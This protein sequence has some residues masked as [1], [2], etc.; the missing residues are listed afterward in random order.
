MW[1]PV[2]ET[3]PIPVAAGQGIMSRAG[4]QPGRTRAVGSVPMLRL[5]LALLLLAAAPAAAQVEGPDLSGEPSGPAQ[6]ATQVFPAERTFAVELFLGVVGKQETFGFSADLGVRVNQLRLRY[7][8]RILFN[9]YAPSSE[10]TQ[11]GR[12]DWI[13]WERP[14]SCSGIA[15][16][17]GGGLST[18]VRHYEFDD[19]PGPQGRGQA[20]SLEGGILFGSRR[21]LPIAMLN[22]ELQIPRD[23][24]AGR[25][26]TVL[27]TLGLDAFLVLGAVSGLH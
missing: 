23:G 17:G 21:A 2:T 5:G 19:V 27:V 18:V 16:Y 12:V 24:R 22:F 3:V 10:T 4:T 20:V 25:T 7:V 9:D 6:P 26:P 13:F 15:A 1:S 11:G 14:E 8:A